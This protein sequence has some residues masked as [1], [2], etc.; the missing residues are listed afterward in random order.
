MVLFKVVKRGAYRL[1][2]RGIRGE[3][4]PLALATSSQPTSQEYWSSYNVTGNRLFTTARESLNSFHWRTSQYYDY[5]HMM[6]VA[7]MDGKVVVDYGCGPGHDLVGFVTAS[8]PARLIGIDVSLPALKQAEHRLRLHSAVADLLH[9]DEG[10][11]RLP[12]P[13]RSVDHIHCSGVLHH[14]PDPQQVLREFRRIVRDGAA[15]RL[16]IYNYDCIWLHLYAAYTV[17]FK[18]LPGSGIDVREAFKRS[19]DTVECPISRAWTPVDVAAMAATAGFSCMHIGNATSV[20]EVAILP[21]RFEAI[22]D[23]NLE[24]EHR[25]FLLG[26]TFDARGLPFHGLQAAGID[27]CYLLKPI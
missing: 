21:D 9:V 26:L 16:M 20:R 12:L 13:D 6:P 22:L 10:T 18:Q 1:F 15:V 19:T 25:S 5:L 7:G 11:P 17:R 14:V 23:P 2:G 3:R 27:G 8:K 24:E 4:A